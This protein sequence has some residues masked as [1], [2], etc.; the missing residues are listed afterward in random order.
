MQRTVNAT[1]E[2]E[3]FSMWFTYIHCWAMDVF[4]VGAPRDYVSNTEL[5]Q[6]GKQERREE[7]ENGVSPRQSRKKG[8]AED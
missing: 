8:L 2:K 1:I 3:V 5:N 4:S 6:I 7:N